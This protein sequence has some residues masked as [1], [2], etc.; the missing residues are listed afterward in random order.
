MK[1]YAAAS[2]A[3]GVEAPTARVGLPL[4]QEQLLAAAHW[5]VWA[6]RRL[7]PVQTSSIF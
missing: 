5:A 7:A 4:R 6:A 2:A 1:L 3:L